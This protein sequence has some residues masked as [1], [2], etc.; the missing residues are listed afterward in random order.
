MCIQTVDVSQSCSFFSEAKQSWL[1]NTSF[2]Q[3]FLSVMVQLRKTLML[4]SMPKIYVLFVC[5]SWIKGLFQPI[6]AH[7]GAMGCRIGVT[8]VL[9]EIDVT[10]VKP[11]QSGQGD[12]I[13]HSRVTIFNVTKKESQNFVGAPRKLCRPHKATTCP[14]SAKNIQMLCNG[15][16]VLLNRDGLSMLGCLTHASSFFLCRLSN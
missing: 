9:E 4:L 14:I 6:R 7:C 16:I 1:Q 5:F 12:P 2:L 10:R 8:V 3:S 11:N 15:C 13:V